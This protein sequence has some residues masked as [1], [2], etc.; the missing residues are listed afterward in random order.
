MAREGLPSIAR[1]AWADHREAAGR[2]MALY[3]EHC[4]GHPPPRVP[5]MDTVLRLAI[6]IQSG[7]TIEEAAAREYLYRWKLALDAPIFG[8]PHALGM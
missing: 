4:Q 1:R 3:R 5:G 8:A 7:R 6:R 2:A